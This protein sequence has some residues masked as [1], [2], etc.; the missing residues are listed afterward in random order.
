VQL[1]L[2]RGL[3]PAQHI[4]MGEALA[5][6]RDEGVLIVGSGMSFHDLR[7]LMTSQGAEP[8]GKFDNWLQEAAQADAPTRNRMLQEWQKAPAARQAHPREEH[9]IPL[10]T[11]AGAAQHDQGQTTFN[12]TFAKARIS[13]IQFG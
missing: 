3:D 4:A 5:P 12:G 11:A 10:M 6:L 13:A 1:S 8:S 2:I 7:A 9:L